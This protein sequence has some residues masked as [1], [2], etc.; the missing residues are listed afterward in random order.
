MPAGRSS[1]AQ[2]V[3]EVAQVLVL[4]WGNDGRRDD[5]LGL[6]AASRIEAMG[7]AAL[8]VVTAYQLQPEHAMDLRGADLV[9]C[10]DAGD[11]QKDAF[12]WRELTPACDQR[13][14]SHAMT[15]AAV[16]ALHA[17][18]EARPAPP[19]F[20]LAIR[21]SDFGV[22]VGLSL[23][24]QQDLAQALAFLLPLFRHRTAHAW[25]RHLAR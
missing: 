2:C 19:A 21:G 8:R 5:G 24:G 17:Q 4:A 12:E 6:H 14:F 7:E 23:Q 9:L 13:V 3:A 20:L 10:V 15:P 18:L 16:L 1:I 11:G 22:G 25:R